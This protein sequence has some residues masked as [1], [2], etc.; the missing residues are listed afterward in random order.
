MIKPEV[1]FFGESVPMDVVNKAMN[2]VTEVMSPSLLLPPLLMFL[3][4]FTL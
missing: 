2:I 4:Y 1:V 3:P